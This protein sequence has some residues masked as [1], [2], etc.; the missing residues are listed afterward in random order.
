MPEGLRMLLLI[1]ICGEMV[2][3]RS[4]KALFRVRILAFVRFTLLVQWIE[5]FTTDEEIGV[6]VSK[7]V[8]LIRSISQV[9]LRLG[10][11]KARSQVRILY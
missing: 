10:S 8:H 3:Y 7:R 4:P 5:H 11:A 2:S 6:R 9:G 1:H